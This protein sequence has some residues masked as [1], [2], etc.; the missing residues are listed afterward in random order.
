ML[1][2]H[3]MRRLLNLRAKIEG[4]IERYGK[5]KRMVDEARG[6]GGDGGGGGKG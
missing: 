6:F 2:Q 3:E 5:L 1:R 4:R